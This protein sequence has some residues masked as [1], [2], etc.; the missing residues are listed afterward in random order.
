M[1]CSP[2]KP[3]WL[4][5]FKSQLDLCI[6]EQGEGCIHL[7]IPGFYEL[8]PCSIAAAVL[9]LDKDAFSCLERERPGQ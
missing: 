4:V 3:A 8:V 2:D 6:T 1:L 7:F 5:E 9:D